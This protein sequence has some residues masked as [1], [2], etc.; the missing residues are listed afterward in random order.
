M[1][2][3]KGKSRLLVVGDATFLRDDALKQGLGNLVHPMLS[4]SQGTAFF[5]NLADSF[6]LDADLVAL[7]TR[8]T[9]DRRMDFGQGALDET[10]DEE[11][12]RTSA[13][14][15]WLKVANIA[16][17]PLLLLAFGVVLLINRSAEK[18]R[19]LRAQNQ[20]AS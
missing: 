3:T 18:N 10:R 20:Q 15:T 1:F 9:K 4:Q 13:Q 19:F 11:K 7:R 12:K 14:K 8:K 2:Q 5:E 6:S 17:T 16:L